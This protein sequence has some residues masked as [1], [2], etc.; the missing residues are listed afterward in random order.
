MLKL[1]LTATITPIETGV[2]CR[3]VI[4]GRLDGAAAARLQATAADVLAEHR[5]VV[6]DLEGVTF[7]DRAGVEALVTVARH[8]REA[9]AWLG[10][11]GDEGVQV[12]IAETPLLDDLPFIR[13]RRD[14][15][16]RAFT[17]WLARN[18]DADP[19]PDE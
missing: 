19:T 14:P 12:A 3:I 2:T 18:S 10:I 1:P 17:R 6:A 11:T 16:R 4:R 8:A 7:I 15:R 5:V 13:S 9:G